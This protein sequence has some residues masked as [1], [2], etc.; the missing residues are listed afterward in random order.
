MELRPSIPQDLS[1]FQPKGEDTHLWKLNAIVREFGNHYGY[2]LIAKTDTETGRIYICSIDGVNPSWN[3]DSI[4][5]FSVIADNRGSLYRG[6]V[7]APLDGD[8]PLLK[9]SYEAWETEKG[10]RISLWTQVNRL[11][12][13]LLLGRAVFYAI[14]YIYF[15]WFHF[16][17]IYISS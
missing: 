13:S 1:Q 11:V 3:E 10:S 4:L 9:V 6:V 16:I 2:K 8:A 5:Q 7:V 12:C 15:I 17:Y 14:F